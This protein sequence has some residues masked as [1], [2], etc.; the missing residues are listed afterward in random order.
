MTFSG[1]RLRAASELAPAPAQLRSVTRP[2]KQAARS[3]V[4]RS[5]AATGE[6]SPGPGRAAIARL[7]AVRPPAPHRPALP[8]APIAPASAAAADA[9][10][11]PA[12]AAEP[13]AAAAAPVAAASTLFVVCAKSATVTQLG[14]GR[15]A[16]CPFL[17]YNS[18]GA[19]VT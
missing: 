14:R 7:A 11:A 15:C 6:P 18:A 1:Q 16:P 2:P 13:A 12:G 3:G 4:P 9:A 10:N 5:A 8:D 17:L 19:Q